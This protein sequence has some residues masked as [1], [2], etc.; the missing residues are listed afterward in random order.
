[1]LRGDIK[2]GDTVRFRYERGQVQW[3]KVSAAEAAPTR[4]KRKRRPAA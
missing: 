2:E 3:E 4:A 1:M